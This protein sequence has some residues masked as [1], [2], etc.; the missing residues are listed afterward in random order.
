M[1]YGEDGGV[2][3]FSM[4][5]VL[6]DSMARGFHRWYSFIVL[7]RDRLLLLNTMPFLQKNA[8]VF[9]ARLQAAASKVH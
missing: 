4:P 3:V 2:S 7:S 1:F 6:K 9:I 5:F 8:S